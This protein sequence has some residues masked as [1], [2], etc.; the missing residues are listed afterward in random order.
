MLKWIKI[1]IVAVTLAIV[2][3]LSCAPATA[4]LTEGQAAIVGG[5]IGYVIGKDKSGNQTQ[6]PV[7]VQQ[8]PPQYPMYGYP[9][10]PMPQVP[11]DATGGFCPYQGEMYYQCLGNLQRLRNEEAYR[12][13]LRGYR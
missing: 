10:Q 2:G 6:Q 12:R 1:R 5:V 4:Q 3:V 11:Y 7:V 13:G 9:V 8:V